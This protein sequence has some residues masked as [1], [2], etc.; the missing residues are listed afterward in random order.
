VIRL[1][2]KE[3]D[4]VLQSYLSQD[5]LHNIYMI[6]GH[7]THGLVSEWVSFW[8][9]FEDSRRLSGVL[10]ANHRP[11]H[12]GCLAGDTA[13]ILETL[14]RFALGSGIN[15][16]IGK[17]LYLQPAIGAATGSLRSRF[18]FSITHLDFYEVRL[19]RFI[20]SRGHPVR[21]ATEDDIP[22]LI[23]L[24]RNYELYPKDWTRKEIEQDIQTV[25]GESGIYFFVEWEGKPVSAARIAVESDCAGIV[26]AATTLPEFRGRGMYSSVRTACCDCLFGKGKIAL[27]LVRN[28]NTP[29]QRI[30]S[31]IGG[32]RTAEWLIVAFKRKL[33]L[34][35]RIL[36]LQLRRWGLSLRNRVVRKGAPSSAWASRS[37]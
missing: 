30:M 19:E 12:F 16:L 18:E 20:P 37:D 2:T 29:M 23:E 7:Q 8:G 31:K 15:K 11:P 10:F 3:D 14:G 13:E 4:D 36:P 6:H 26:D 35:R 32:C 25:I 5:P 17:N 1:L 34:R 24:Y 27:G 21:A 28:D 22:L 33:P 9:A